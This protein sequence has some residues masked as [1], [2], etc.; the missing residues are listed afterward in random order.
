MLFSLILVLS[1]SSVSAQKPI[2]YS[3]ESLQQ[4]G[5]EANGLVQAA[6]SQVGIAESNVI[7]AGAL[8]NPNVTVMAGP[9]SNRLPPSV[10]GPS[11][12]QHEVT[13]S[14]PIE[15]P[16]LRSARIG[17]AKYGVE[18]NE[19]NL[20]QVRVNLAAQLRVSAYELLLR[21][22]LG[23]METSVHDL[24]EEIQQRIQVSVDVGESARFELI[25]ADTEVL[26]AASRMEA[27]LLNAERA[28][29]ALIQLTA[30]AL[31]NDFEIEAH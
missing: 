7:S 13:V 28:R 27:A 29:V 2:K 9:Q 22:E 10:T 4:L 8:P 25:R 12:N 11:N 16:F 5:L 24:M 14:Q 6:R 17:S 21:Q 30:G 19:A 15:N 3:I 26:S 23:R 1:T 31:P 20:D 18:A